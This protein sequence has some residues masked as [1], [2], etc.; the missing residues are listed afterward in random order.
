MED[1]PNDKIDEKISD[2]SDLYAP[3]PEIKNNKDIII[4]KEGND[5]KEYNTQLDN[6][7]ENNLK[8]LKDLANKFSDKKKIFIEEINNYKDKIISKYSDSFSLFDNPDQEFKN[9]ISEN[10]I[11]TAKDKYIQ[12]MGNINKLYTQIFDSIKQ[13]LEMLNKFI[14]K[15]TNYFKDDKE[16]EKD[17]PIKDYLLEE[18]NNIINC[19]LLK[20][21]DFIN[22]NFDFKEA[23]SKNEYDENFK[24]YVLNTF[25][26]KLERIDIIVPKGENIDKNKNVFKLL[27]ENHPYLIKLQLENVGNVSNIIDNKLKFNKLK[28]LYVGNSTITSGNLFKNME[29]LEKLK[30]KSSPNIP[31]ELIEYTPINI[32]YLLL[33][34]NNYVDFEFEKIL[35]YILSNNSNILQNL[36]YLSFAGNNLTRIDLSILPNKVIFERLQSINFQK[37]KI[38]KF[39]YFP[40]NYPKL[41]FINCCKNNLNKSYLGKIKKIGSLESENFF[42]FETSLCKKYYDTLKKK[43]KENENDLFI[44]KYLNLTYMQDIKTSKYFDDF[45]INEKILNRLTKLDLSFNGLDCDTFFKFVKQNGGFSNVRSL[46]LNGNE[47]DEIFFEICLEHNFFPNLRHLYLNS[48]KIGDLKIENNNNKN[49]DNKDKDKDK[50]KEKEKEIDHKLVHIMRLLYKFIQK[51]SCLTK[52]TITK[53]PISQFHTI[54][55]ENNKDADKNE[56]YIKK[57]NNKIIINCLFSLLVKIRDELLPKEEENKTGR[58]HF[59]LRF[60]CRSNVNRNSENYPYSDKPIIKKLK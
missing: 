7:L 41:K 11:K 46:N 56:K 12:L 38:Y 25:K 50:D 57:E 28:K 24:T 15:F 13:N 39:I 51:N 42:L 3:P 31:I 23:L 36:E 33:E 8:D 48:N 10:V 43:L 20:K 1:N 49:N 5:L 27:E 47:F 59:N 2:P 35:K 29:K 60:D 40:D 32:K 21:I 55:L 53:N 37:N 19:W 34:K 22:F 4:P 26:K 17:D 18:F 58:K 16:K 52:L 44:T 14:D 45:K 6:S 54:V 9:D 30:I